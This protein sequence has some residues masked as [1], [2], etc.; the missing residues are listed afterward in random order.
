[1]RSLRWF[2]LLTIFTNG[3]AAAQAADTPPLIRAHAH[4]DYEHPRP[5]LDALACGFGSIEADVHLVDGRLLVAHDRKAVKPER[6]LEAL[7]LDPLRERVKQNGG[8]VYRGGPTIIL[9]IDVKSEA[10]ATYDALHAVLKNYAAMLT[11]FRDGVTTPGAITVIVSGSRAPAV[12]AAQSLRYAAMDGRIDDLNG[13][14]AP[15]LIPL[16]SDNWQKVFSWRWTGPIPEDEARKLKAL[17]EQAHAQGRQLRFW[18]TPDNPATWSVLY[19]A[20]VDLINT[21]QLTGLQGFLRAQKSSAKIEN[22]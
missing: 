3:K 6:T 12:M 13:Q 9:L 2:L 18:N 10:V 4:N 20:G 8:C 14:T 15:A 16:V 11:V 5:L 21:D 19:G 7:Y 17:V 1:M 22:R